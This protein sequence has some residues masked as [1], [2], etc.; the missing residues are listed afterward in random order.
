MPSRSSF[1]WLGETLLSEKYAEEQ[2]VRLQ[3]GLHALGYSGLGGG[4][5]LEQAAGP[6]AEDGG[7]R[8]SWC[9]SRAGRRAGVP[10]RGTSHITAASAAR[11]EQRNGNGRER[12]RPRP[13][14]RPQRQERPRQGLAPEPR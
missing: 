11:E 7:E 13:R 4:E 10:A 6:R 5:G 12:L 14:Q 1:L 8:R 3:L 2:E 9:D